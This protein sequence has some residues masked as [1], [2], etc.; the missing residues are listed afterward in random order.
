MTQEESSRLACRISINTMIGNIL[1]TVAKLM[2]GIFGHSAAMISDAAHSASDVLSTVAVLLGIR[3]AS[4]RADEQHPY[5]HEKMECVAAALLALILIVTAAGIGIFGVKKLIQCVTGEPVTPGETAMWAALISIGVKE[6]M[7]QYTRRG[8]NRIGSTALQADAWHHRSDALS[9]IGALAGVAGARLGLPI[10]DPIVS[11]T[12]SGIIFIVAFRIMKTALSQMIDTAAPDE[13]EKQ[14]REI[15]GTYREIKGIDLLK[16]RM[17]GSRV[18]VDV[19]VQM[20]KNM[21]LQTAHAVAQDLHNE[22]EDQNPQI[23]HCMIH[24]NPA[25]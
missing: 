25:P 13:V 2:A 9:S 22:I 11:L 15:I 19:E 6:W 1:L 4:K 23:K 3:M 17:S 18:Y 16:T 24:I 21:M 20:D 7:Y 8:A 5:G 14:I 10:L 12:I